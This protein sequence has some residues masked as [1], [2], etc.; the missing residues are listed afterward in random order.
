MKP[1]HSSR[2]LRWRWFA[3]AAFAVILF[4]SPRSSASAVGNSYLH[5]ELIE[6]LLPPDPTYT[7]STGNRQTPVAGQFGS[8]ISASAGR[9][10]VGAPFGRY[11]WTP[12]SGTAAIFDLEVAGSPA[13]I[14]PTQDLDHELG[15]TVAIG[16]N[17]GVV[18]VEDPKSYSDHLM[19]VDSADGSLKRIIN[20]PFRFASSGFGS[21]IAISEDMAVVGSPN[22]DGSALSSG[23]AFLYNLN[24]GQQIRNFNPPNLGNSS[25]LGASV[26]VDDARIVLGAPGRNTAFVYDRSNLARTPVQLLPDNASM[27]PAFG[28]VIDLQGDYVL[29]SGTP[30]GYFS[31]RTLRG[32]AYLFDSKTGEQLFK[33]TSPN[34][35]VDD[36]F[37]AAVALA[38]GIAFVGAPRTFTGGRRGA[39]HAF[40]VVSGFHLGTLL[41]DDLAFGFG[42]AL[43][44]LGSRLFVGSPSS[45]SA[46]GTVGDGAVHIFDTSLSTSPPPMAEPEVVHLSVQQIAISG[47]PG[48]RQIIVNVEG[49]RAIEGFEAHLQGPLNQVRRNRPSTFTDDN[50]LISRTG[51]LVEAD[52]QFLFDSRQLLALEEATEGPTSL[53]GHFLFAGLDAGRTG[54]FPL[55]QVVV[56]IG[57][58]FTLEGFA[59]IGG[60]SVPLYLKVTAVPE[61]SGVIFTLLGLGGAFLYRRRWI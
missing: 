36:E 44:T 46:T 25:F 59:Y 12:N 6:E 14:Y 1:N 55:A 4:L 28:G 56:P 29:V 41:P 49:S 5:A 42:S 2:L 17:Y 13:R 57:E 53:E 38:D 27:D 40:D 30:G 52:S 37:G 51:G 39:V 58:Q 9:L 32:A 3:L 20:S 16:P 61:P 24:T 43:E 54:S 31:S 48:Y 8:S 7:N 10:L 21:A 34:G 15:G 45:N 26:A 60:Q 22:A 11:T 47:L 50:W 33:F 18:S 35:D 19:V 23:A